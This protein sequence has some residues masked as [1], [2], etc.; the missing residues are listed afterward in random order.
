MI[1]V[2]LMRVSF[3]P[4]LVVFFIKNIKTNTKRKSLKLDS[5]LKSKTSIETFLGKSMNSITPVQWCPLIKALSIYSTHFSL[6]ELNIRTNKFSVIIIYCSF[7]INKY[8]LVWLRYI[9]DYVLE[10]R[11]TVSCYKARATLMYFR[12]K[13]FPFSY[14]SMTVDT[15]IFIKETLTITYHATHQLILYVYIIHTYYKVRLWMDF[16]CNLLNICLLSYLVCEKEWSWKE[17]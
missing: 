15:F 8:W 6:F 5:Q 11:R 14:F 16:S 7:F 3:A 12:G 10:F 1:Y 9:Y 4:F 17:N 13:V 2:V